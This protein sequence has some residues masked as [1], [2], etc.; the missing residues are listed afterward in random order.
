MRSASDNTKVMLIKTRT[1]GYGIPSSPCVYG[2][3]F[4]DKVVAKKGIDK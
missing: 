1:Y 3:E 4:V 2:R